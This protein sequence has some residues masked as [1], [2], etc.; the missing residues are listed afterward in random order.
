MKW[1]KTLWAKV[2]GKKTAGGIAM[3]VAGYFML[4]CPDAQVSAF[5]TYLLDAGV[6]LAGFGAIHKVKKG[7]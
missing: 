4:K 6:A 7:K 2:D 1:L 3:A 5:G